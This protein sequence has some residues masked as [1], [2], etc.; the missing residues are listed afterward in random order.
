MVESKEAALHETGDLLVPISEGLFAPEQLFAELGEIVAGLK[1]GREHSDE[2]TVF[3][4]VGLAAMDVVVGKIL[5]DRAVELGL[6]QK[7]VL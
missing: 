3:K 1:P 5:Y 4:S 2:T 6:G 7:V